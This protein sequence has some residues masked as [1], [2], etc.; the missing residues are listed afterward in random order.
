[1]PAIRSSYLP[2]LL[3]AMAA[4][5]AWERRMSFK[6]SALSRT[7]SVLAT[8]SSAAFDYFHSQTFDTTLSL[9]SVS[10]SN[11]PTMPASFAKLP[12]AFVK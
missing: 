9:A 12:T 4:S 7:D 11:T 1:M 2:L 8:H 5:A 10:C 6:W 3:I